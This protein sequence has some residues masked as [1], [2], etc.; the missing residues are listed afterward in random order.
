[1]EILRVLQPPQSLL[2]LL[3]P[4]FRPSLD[5]L[6]LAP[7]ALGKA[8]E[9]Q[10]LMSAQTRVC[11]PKCWPF[12]LGARSTNTR[13]TQSRDAATSWRR[14]QDRYFDRNRRRPA[15]TAVAARLS[16]H[17]AEVWHG[18]KTGSARRRWRK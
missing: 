6:A 12:L 17:R 4:N 16:A 11:R 5:P 1:R 2:R 8:P 10:I 18:K 14:R 13:K 15:A 3:R 9:S 7:H